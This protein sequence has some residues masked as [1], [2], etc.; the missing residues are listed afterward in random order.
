M[1]QFRLTPVMGKRLIAKATATHPAITRTLKSGSIVI[2]AGTTNGCV[3]EE[4]LNLIGQKGDFNRKRFFRGITLP[5][6]YRTASAGRLES[7]NPIPGDVVIKDGIWQKGKT[8][9][10]VADGLKEGDVIIKG[11]N[12]L[13]LVHRR[14]AVLI[15]APDGGTITVALRAVLGR[16]VNLIVPIGLE[17][18]ISG[19]L[20]QIANRLNTPGEKGFRFLPIP[21]EV[22]TE[23]ESLR[24][25]TGVEAEMIAAGGVSGAEGSIWLAYKGSDE[26]ER[27]AEKL[28]Q[29]LEAEPVFT[30]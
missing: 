21:G 14:A 22:I 1:K 16:R 25:L 11:A 30:V 6:N 4:I 15:G 27:A 19:D 3:A 24:M 10:D 18:R 23:I 9:N 12:A 5:P 8:I 2:V 20:D 17:K 26:A 29:T 13:D 28:L 7:E